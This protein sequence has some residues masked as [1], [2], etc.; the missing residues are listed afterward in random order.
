MSSSANLSPS[1]SLYSQR[2]S[3]LVILTGQVPGTEIELQSPRTILGRGPG[4]D[5]V[6]PDEAMSRQHF[7]MEVA[8]GG[9]R[10]R[11][12]GSTNGLE[13]N[14]KP[15]DT[16]EMQHGDRLRA[17]SHEFQLLVE[18]MEREPRTWVVGE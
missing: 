5:V 16:A 13:L 6:I 12:L 8:G 9:V 15:V 17:G 1:K 2:R 7:A 10:V 4:V 3:C 14:G 18:E 11:D